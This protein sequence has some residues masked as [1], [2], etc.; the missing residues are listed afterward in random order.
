MFKETKTIL[1]NRNN[2]DEKLSTGIVGLWWTLWIINSLTGYYVNI[3]DK[4]DVSLES[5]QNITFIGM[6]SSAI[7]IILAPITVKMISNYSAA[8]QILAEESDNSESSTYN[9]LIG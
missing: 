5:L 6:F 4:N 2:I 9:S 3:V 8:E 1:Q 7:V